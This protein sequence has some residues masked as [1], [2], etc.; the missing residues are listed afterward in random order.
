MGKRIGTA[1]VIALSVMGFLLLAPY[2]L[3]QD[4]SWGEAISI[5]NTEASSWFPAV[6]VDSMGRV[7]VVWTENW[8]NEEQESATDAL[9]YAV[10]NGESWATPNDLYSATQ[11][12]AYTLRPSLVIDRADTLHLLYRHPTVFYHMRTSAEAAWSA[13][14]WSD[15]HRV[16]GSGESGWADLA[17]DSQGVLHAV[18]SEQVT[19][20]S[21]EEEVLV[22]SDL[23]Y[24]HSSDGGL[25]WSIPQ[26][27]SQ[28]KN[29]ISNSLHI[30][31]DDQDVIHV[32]WDEEQ[33]SRY[34]SS[35]DGGDSWIGP[36]AFYSIAGT[37]R[38]IVSAVDGEGQI[39]IAW[40]TIPNE[41]QPEEKRLVYYQT[42]SDGGYSWSMPDAIPGLLAR[43]RNDTPFDAYDMAVDSAGHVHLVVVGQTNP[44]EVGLSVLH[45]EWDGDE[46]SSFTRIFSTTD[47]PERPAIT[48]SGGNQ[49][50]VVW[51]MRGVENQF[52]E[53]GEYQVWYSRG[54]S[55]APATTPLPSPTPLPAPTATHTRAPVPSVTPYP[56]LAPETSSLPPGLDTES[57]E[58]IRLLFALLPLLML[59]VIIFV[60]R[61]GWLKRLF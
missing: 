47:L 20:K 50:H 32:V 24:R 55:A 57:D 41:A 26:N 12:A 36:V 52:S 38:Q 6:A 3:A 42:S 5:S 13:M 59:V 15:P 23:F 40:R 1:L 9:F 48:V 56:T 29:P 35:T 14:D 60:V 31:I 17:I 11:A 46:W 33:T 45:T 22:T 28:S 27:L 19:Y 53:E 37:P 16:S 39:V 4:P 61:R 44:R 43:S 2:S 49:L 30:H 21:S 8:R 7:H 58:V 54:Q 25:S 51:F 10:W 34:A 18:W